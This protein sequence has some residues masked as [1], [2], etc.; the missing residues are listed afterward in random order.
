MRPIKIVKLL[1]SFMVAPIIGGVPPILG[2]F[3]FLSLQKINDLVNTGWHRFRVVLVG[4]Y[5]IIF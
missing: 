2:K 3:M 4:D 5:I 1:T